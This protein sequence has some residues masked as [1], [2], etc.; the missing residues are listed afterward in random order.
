MEVKKSI[1]QK[2]KRREFDDISKWRKVLKN[3]MKMHWKF[4]LIDAWIALSGT[5][6]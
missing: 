2:W 6:F 5:R 3:K 4:N 1:K